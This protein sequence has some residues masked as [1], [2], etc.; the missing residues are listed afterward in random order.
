MRSRTALL[1]LLFS[2]SAACLASPQAQTP[3]DPAVIDAQGYQKLIQDYRGKPLLITFWATWCEPCRYEYPMLNELAKRYAPEG[4]KVVG[5]SLDD[6]GEMLLVR[7]F[8]AKYQPVFP[9]YRKRPAK[10]E[11]FVG[12][13]NPRWNGAIPASFLYSRDGR[14]IGQLSGGAT[15]EQ[16]EAAIRSLLTSGEISNHA[17]AHGKNP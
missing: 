3:P 6:D 4:L 12:V 17:A 15:R 1:A 11:E 10:Q 2:T 9:N 7:R 8:L 13:V 5:I 16:F 14:Q